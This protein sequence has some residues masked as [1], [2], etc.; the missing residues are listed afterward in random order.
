MPVPSCLSPFTRD[1]LLL[2]H[3]W[4]RIFGKEEIKV[5]IL[6]LDN[7]G[8]VGL[9]LSGLAAGGTL[10]PFSVCLQTC[11]VLILVAIACVD[12]FVNHSRIFR[13]Q[14]STS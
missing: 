12:A 14:S 10:V 2:A 7:A 3:Q 11:R 9:A 8:K 4:E 5:C 6:G 1:P 13:R